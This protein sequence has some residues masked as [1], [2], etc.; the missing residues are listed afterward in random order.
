MILFLIQ[1]NSKDAHARSNAACPQKINS[2]FSQLI[3]RYTLG[4]WNKCRTNK[5]P[6]QMV[7]GIVKNLKNVAAQEELPQNNANIKPISISPCKKIIRFW[8]TLELISDVLLFSPY[9]TI[10]FYRWAYRYTLDW[11]EYSPTLLVLIWFIFHYFIGRTY[12]FDSL[13]KINWR[14]TTH[15]LVNRKRIS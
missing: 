15:S 14:V 7:S 13:H 12:N 8:S 10:L 11:S 6:V 3:L 9:N 5:I 1:N 2:I 4:T